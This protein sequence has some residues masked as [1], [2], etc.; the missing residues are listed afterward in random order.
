MRSDHGKEFENDYFKSFC[1]EMGITHNFSSPRT[2]QQNRVVEK[3]IRVLVE[4]ARTILNE[5]N[6]TKYFWSEAIN[7]AC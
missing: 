3:K 2:P 5:Y 4:M 6:L 1:N 7:T